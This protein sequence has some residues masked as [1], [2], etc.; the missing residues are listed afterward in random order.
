[1]VGNITRID[2]RE[3]IPDSV[4][5][6]ADQVEVIDIEPEELIDRMK[7]RERFMESSRQR[8]HSTIFSGERSWL[9][10]GKLLFAGPQTG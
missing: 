7:E 4:F 8:G 2:V 9:P 5:D 1:M 6:H 3:R 10:F